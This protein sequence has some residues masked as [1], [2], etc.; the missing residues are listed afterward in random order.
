MGETII[1]GCYYCS[2]LTIGNAVNTM[3]S[4]THYSSEYNIAS[5]LDTFPGIALADIESRDHIYA[6]TYERPSEIW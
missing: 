1:E 3:V 2:Q 6:Q 5:L 4:P